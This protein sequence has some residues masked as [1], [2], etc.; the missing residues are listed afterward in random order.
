[1]RNSKNTVQGISRQALLRLPNYLNYLKK[2]QSEGVQTVSA[3]KIAAALGQNEV[4][5]RKDIAF[6]SSC[7]GK[8][9]TGFD[10]T[11]L[12]RDLESFLGYD[13]VN[14]AV[15]VGA[16]K[17]AFELQRL[18]GIRRAYRR[19]VRHRR[20]PYRA[21]IRHRTTDFPNGKT[22]RPLR[23]NADSHRHCDCSRR[24]RASGL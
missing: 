24:K 10:T 9:K 7:A 17:S 20:N 5:V 8:P 13:N 4:Q 3:P 6:V 11:Q 14:E 19:R 21:D 1:M 12:V 2:L 18:C 22:R 16:G 23:T 15:L